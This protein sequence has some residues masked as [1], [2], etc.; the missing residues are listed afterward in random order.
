MVLGDWSPP[1]TRIRESAWDRKMRGFWR[2]L[3]SAWLTLR[4][5]M[6]APRADTGEW[7]SGARGL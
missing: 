3:A 5:I 6:L 7:D 2:T 1:H 4:R